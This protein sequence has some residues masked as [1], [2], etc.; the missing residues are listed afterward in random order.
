[1]RAP[2][3]FISSV[4]KKRPIEGRPPAG[5]RHFGGAAVLGPGFEPGSERFRAVRRAELDQPS[6]SVVIACLVGRPGIEPGEQKRL[7]YK[8]PRLHSGL[9]PRICVVRDVR[10]RCEAE[11]ETT[12]GPP[13]GFPRWPFLEHRVHSRV[14]QES[15]LDRILATAGEGC[16]FDENLERPWEVRHQRPT[17]PI[18]IPGDGATLPTH[19]VRLASVGLRPGQVMEGR[20]LHGLGLVR[21]GPWFGLTSGDYFFRQHQ[22]PPVAGPFR[23]RGAN[24][25]D[26]VLLKATGVLVKLLFSKTRNHATSIVSSIA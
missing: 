26:A 4:F 23:S 9:P 6:M 8:Q 7:F 10:E 2:T 21:S 13:G 20:G 18:G 22:P 15:L 19:R 16:A 1:M 5:L 11:A 25:P 12:K 14:L 3:S 17:G 24:D